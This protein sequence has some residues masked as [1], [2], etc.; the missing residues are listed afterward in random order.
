MSAFDATAAAEFAS[1]LT[2]LRETDETKFFDENPAL[3]SLNEWLDQC[4]ETHR[5]NA[6]NA[7]ASGL[8]A[9][10]RE[11]WSWHTGVVS[12]EFRA[13]LGVPGS[14]TELGQLIDAQLTALI[15]AA[16]VPEL[17]HFTVKLLEFMAKMQWLPV[18]SQVPLWH[19]NQT[20]YTFVDVLAYDTVNKCIVLLEIKTG[21]DHGYE[22]PIGAPADD[23]DLF[24]DSHRTRHQQQLCWMLVVLRAELPPDVPVIGCVLRVSDRAGV[25][26]PDWSDAAVSGFFE[27]VYISKDPA[28]QRVIAARA[29]EPSQVSGKLK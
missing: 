3:T 24:V 28:Y 22:T 16:P 25:R 4:E 12:R 17:H 20:T 1:R 9:H 19:R 27:S 7:T 8:L 10:L 18:S 15:L 5:L 2:L 6:Q 29:S 14:C 13:S 23:D 26:E 21:Y 11:T